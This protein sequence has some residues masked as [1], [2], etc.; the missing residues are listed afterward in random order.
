MN[1]RERVESVGTVCQNRDESLA[2]DESR[3]G[4]QPAWAAPGIEVA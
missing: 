1:H 3:R 2:W 4:L